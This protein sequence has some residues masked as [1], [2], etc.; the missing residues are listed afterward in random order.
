MKVDIYYNLL[1]YAK[2]ISLYDYYISA[3]VITQNYVTIIFNLY[4]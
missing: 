3:T 4:Y 1:K 2:D